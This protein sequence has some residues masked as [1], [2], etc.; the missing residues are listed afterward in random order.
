MKAR[1]EKFL[2]WMSGAIVTPY[3]AL[4]ATYEYL[5]EILR[6][7]RN[8]EFRRA[9]LA[10][11][12]RY[13]LRSPYRICS[14]F[15]ESYPDEEV[16]KVYG[17]TSLMTLEIIAE[18]VRLTADDTLYEL[19][20][21]RGRSVFWFHAFHGCHTIGVELNPYFLR[22]ANRVLSSFPQS[23]VEFREANLLDLDYADA[24]VVYLY[25]TLF[26]EVAVSRLVEQLRNLQ[27]G[28][29]VVTVTYPLTNDIEGARLFDLVDQFEA[30]FLWGTT[31]VFIHH[32][33]P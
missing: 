24:T 3:Y 32:R 14:R 25:G 12:G 8:R 6:Y 28:A 22:E 4:M 27:P 31:E 30:P 26:Q 1:W 20:S 15:L 29:R 33:L 13:F 9:D 17:E 7:Y 10:L 19:G 11:V 21:G 5:F 16:Q 23:R 18:K 2:G